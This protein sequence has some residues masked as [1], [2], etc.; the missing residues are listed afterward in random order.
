MIRYARTCV[1]ALVAAGGGIAAC[2]HLPFDELPLPSE[3]V[4]TPPEAGEGGNGEVDGGLG[5]PTDASSHPDVKPPPPPPKDAGGDGG[6]CASNCGATFVSDAVG[7]D[8]NPGTAAA[9]LKTIGK[10][11]TVAALRKDPEIRVAAGTYPEQ[12]TLVEGIDLLGG[13]E[14]DAEPCPWTRD[15]ENNVSTIVAQ[16][17]E[18]V[19]VP[20]TVTAKTRVDGFVIKGKSGLLPGSGSTGG[21]AISVVGGTPIISHCRIVGGD[22]SSVVTTIPRRSIGVAVLGPS[23][24]P[25][26]LQLDHDSISSG[27][28]QDAS[29][30]VLLDVLTN[31]NNTPVIGLTA[32]VVHGGAA[33]LSVG[34]LLAASGSGTIVQRSDIAGGASTGTA[35]GLL[36][37]WGI[38]A[39]GTATIDGNRINTDPTNVGT[40]AAIAGPPFCGGG[41]I[42]QGSTSIITNNVILGAKGPRTAGVFLTAA[43]GVAGSVV[44]NANTI[45]GGGSAVP[46]S[47]STALAFGPAAGNLVV[48]RVRNNILLSGVNATRYGAFEVDAS[49]KT[50][51]PEAFTNDWFYDTVTSGST[52]V[53]YR[54]WNGTSGQD[55]T[56]DQ[57]DTLVSNGPSACDKNDPKLDP[58]YH[59]LNDSPCIDKGTSTEAPAKDRDGDPRPLGNA[60]D[61]GADEAK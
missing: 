58:S 15:V 35:N 17:F 9:P 1:L 7:S 10:A 29:I 3:L 40:C 11:Y 56:I 44:L 20:S 61:I 52:D 55:L 16:T 8:T 18:G 24:A 60:V 39:R 36:G 22:V 38:V 4:T 41:L 34:V 42:S 28:A 27:A 23:N 49:N 14:C 54:F 43:E 2:G 33:P 45:A 53:V 31:P 32:S 50:A 5:E 51:H 21:A 59:L 19:A 6:P 47:L 30:G 12:V 25:A 48:G 13:Y 46:A 57:L 37:S 26:G